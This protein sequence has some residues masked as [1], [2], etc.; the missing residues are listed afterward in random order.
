M[1]PE[2]GDIVLA[3]DGDHT[4]IADQTAFQMPAGTTAERTGTY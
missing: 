4:F 2:D 3:V 1:L